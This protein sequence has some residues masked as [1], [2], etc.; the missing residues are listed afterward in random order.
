MEKRA[1]LCVYVGLWNDGKKTSKLK[2][3]FAQNKDEGNKMHMMG[4]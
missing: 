1:P 2:M 3:F 4:T